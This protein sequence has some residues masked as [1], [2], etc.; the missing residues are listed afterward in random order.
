M[1]STKARPRHQEPEFTDDQ[2]A[3]LIAGESHWQPLPAALDVILEAAPELSEEIF[4]TDL[5]VWLYRQEGHLTFE[6]LASH[7]TGYGGIIPRKKYLR[8]V[9]QH[10]RAQ[11]LVTVTNFKT[12]D[13]AEIPKESEIGKGS[14]VSLSRCGMSWLNRAL[15]ARLR[16]GTHLQHCKDED[17]VVADPYWVEDIVKRV[18]LALGRSAK[19]IDRESREVARR[20][21][22]SVF[23]L[24][25][26]R[27]P[28]KKTRKKTDF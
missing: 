5:L 15:T 20:A 6:D 27:P 9:L 16:G 12:N 25:P 7:A 17:E 4:R 28:A 21:P 13:E 11:Y 26:A 14:L 3:E 10:M 18:D 19:D 23:A 24:A 1:R 2:V 22:V 8:R